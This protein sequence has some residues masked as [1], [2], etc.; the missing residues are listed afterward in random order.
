[1]VAS[2]RQTSARKR[3]FPSERQRTLESEPAGPGLY[4]ETRAYRRIA[5]SFAQVKR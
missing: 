2:R 3:H 4:G 5:Q 1:L